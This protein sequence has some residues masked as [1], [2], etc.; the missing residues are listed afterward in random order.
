M[1]TVLLPKIYNLLSIY[2]PVIVILTDTRHKQTPWFHFLGYTLYHAPTPDIVGGV[3]ILVRSDI[4]SCPATKPF[5][6][7]HIGTALPLK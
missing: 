7:P 1:L 2:K 5:N 3:I 4:P 6:S